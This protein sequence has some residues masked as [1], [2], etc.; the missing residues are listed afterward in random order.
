MWT[1][2][3][4]RQDQRPTENIRHLQTLESMIFPSPWQN[5]EDVVKLSLESD[6]LGLYTINEI[7][8]YIFIP[9]IGFIS[10]K[11]LG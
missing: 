10:N 8:C 9:F 11:L 6:K 5:V 1:L 2:I 7:C 4:K 3:A